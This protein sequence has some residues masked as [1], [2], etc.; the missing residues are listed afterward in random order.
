MASC[1]YFPLSELIWDEAYN[2][3]SRPMMKRTRL[4]VLEYSSRSF[5]RM[6]TFFDGDRTVHDYVFD[7]LGELDRVLVGGPVNDFIGVARAR[8]LLVKLVCIF[9]N[10]SG[11][12]SDNKSSNF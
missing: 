5:S 6:D 8:P 1:I 2:L 12:L 10:S 7:P 3:I 9:L 4:V 11:L